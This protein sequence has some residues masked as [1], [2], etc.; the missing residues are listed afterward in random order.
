M[1]PAF[2]ILFGLLVLSVPLAAASEHLDADVDAPENDSEID[3]EV[4]RET[5]TREVS[6]ERDGQSVEIESEQLNVTSGIENA[7]EVSFEADERVEIE[8]QF[9]REREIN[10]S[11]Q[12]AE[13]SYRVRTE[14][15]VEY[16][17]ANGNGVL[18]DGEAVSRYSLDDATFEPL[19]YTTRETTNGVTEHVITAQSRD[20][21]FMVTLHA[22]GQF[23]DI[24]ATT[25]NPT[26]VKIDLAMNDYP[27]E[28]NDTRLALVSTLRTEHETEHEDDGADDDDTA[29]AEAVTISAG[30]V[31]GFFSWTR[32]ATVDGTTAQITSAVRPGEEA[33][34]Q[35]IVLSYPHGDSIVHDPKIGISL[36]QDRGTMLAVY[37]V[38]LVIAAVAVYGLWRYR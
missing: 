24:G 14:A 38:L 21:V 15:L 17:D 23:A 16:T 13:L 10:E 9:S 11:E 25:V 30:D 6:V 32:T 28:R 8:L 3:S 36:G 18:D 37:A 26:E 4:E 31:S 27:Y 7:F 2:A 29:S 33:G 34:E 1:R 35:Q 22:V 20:G 12:E 19:T 5:E